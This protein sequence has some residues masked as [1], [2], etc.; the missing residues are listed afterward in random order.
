MSKVVNGAP[1]AVATII[2]PAG[3]EF[4]HGKLYVTYDVFGD[5]KVGTINL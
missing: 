1:V 5:G 4:A 2:N 3:L